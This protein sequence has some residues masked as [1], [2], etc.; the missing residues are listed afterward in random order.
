M[1]VTAYVLPVIDRIAMSFMDLIGGSKPSAKHSIPSEVDAK[2]RFEPSRRLLARLHG[3]GAACALVAGRDGARPARPGEHALGN[4]EA[5]Q[6]HPESARCAL[7][8]S[9]PMARAERALR[10]SRTG[11]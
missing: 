5:A 11:A 3:R 7:T 2:A 6:A 1:D 10:I 4:L 9:V 8:P